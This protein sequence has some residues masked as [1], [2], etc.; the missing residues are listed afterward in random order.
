MTTLKKTAVTAALALLAL[1][2]VS[3]A[4]V[5]DYRDIKTPP[6]RQFEMAQPKRIQLANGMVILLQE[7]HELP[8]IHGSAEIRGGERDVPAA[9][10]GLANIYGSA[11]RTGGTQSK[12]GDDL[13]AFLEARAARVETNADDDSSSVAINVLKGD[14]DTVFPIF[15]ELLQKPAFRQ[16]K[17]DLARTQMNTMIS[18]RNDDPGSI[19][20]REATKLAYGADSPYARVPE[21][22]TV[23]SITRDDL[24]AFHDRFV[25]PNNIIIGL[26]GDFDSA[27]MEKKLRDAF[28]SWKRGPQAPPPVLGGTPAKPGVYF[29]AKDDVTQANIS[30]VHAGGPLRSSPDYPA[31]AV[32]NEILSGGFSG[33]LM[34]HIRSQMGLAYGVGGGL[35]AGWDHPSSFNVTM[36]TKSGSTLQSIDALRAEVRDLQTTPF[37]SDELSLAKDSILNKYV[38]TMDSP[39][40]VLNQ[41]MALEFYGYP[42]DFWQKYP[43]AIE[44]VTS[45]DVERVAKKYVQPNQ[46]AVLVVGKESDFEKPLSTLGTVTAID[47]TIPEP[48]GATKPAAGAAPAAAPAATTAEG[49]ALAKKV[50]EFTG[51]KAAIDAVK[52][53]RSVVA[54]NM[55]TPQ[56]PMEMEMDQLLRYP[57]AQRRV[58]KMPMGEVTMVVSP[59]AAFM[60]T[61][62][63]MQDLPGSQRDA[64]K[65]ESSFELLTVLKNVESPAYIFATA[66]EEKVGDANAQVLS[67]AHGST[68]VK[69][70]VDPAT[71]KVLRLTQAGRGGE[72]I[73]DYTSWK[74]FGGLNLPAAF[75]V[76]AN[77]QKS[78]SG[79]LKSVEVNPTIEA[80]AFEKPAAK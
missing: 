63:G 67:I 56:G 39:S 25:Y 1:A 70:H 55:T 78:G 79:E 12:S 38:F 19:L 29:V 40:K 45:A 61:P 15:V 64:M 11:W 8:L 31:I 42:A 46:L 69:W 74:K 43:G 20:R 26:A 48:G 13:D 3:T 80:N 33:R 30:A 44:K 28:G 32:M 59:T 49:S 5:N 75:T 7:D 9:K 10:A 17:I 6:L 53:T 21:Y 76:T 50:R 18:R 14:F 16:D 4:Q 65:T 62:M 71:G 73:T 51:G 66:G 60:I 54:L 27:K 37:T 57:D 23:A 22:A 34:N 24:L 36:S 68:T 52:A 72:Q 35:G 2:S 41:R 77:G 47:I 58:M